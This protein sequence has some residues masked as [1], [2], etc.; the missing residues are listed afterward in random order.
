MSREEYISGYLDGV[1]GNIS[2]WE[3]NDI[4]QILGRV[5]KPAAFKKWWNTPIP[6]WGGS[7]P[8]EVWNS[9]SRGRLEVHDLVLG[10][11]DPGFS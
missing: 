7:T 11:L 2:T 5:L 8:L 3:K 6:R 10:Y 4:E 9:G 1:I